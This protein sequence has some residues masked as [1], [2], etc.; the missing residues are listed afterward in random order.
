MFLINDHLFSC[1][2]STQFSPSGILTPNESSLTSNWS[3][4]RIG[5]FSTGRYCAKKTLEC[6]GF[7]HHDILIGENRE[8]LWPDG[9]TGSISHCDNLVGAITA[10]TAKVKAIGLDIEIIGRVEQELWELVFTST[11]RDFLTQLTPELAAVNSTIIFSAKECFYKLQYPL[12]KI[13][14]D[15]KDVEIFIEDESLQISFV[16]GFEEISRL[17]QNVVMKYI[18]YN[19]EVITYGYLL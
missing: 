9:V 7:K 4:K 17:F 1:F 6:L 19:T 12:T 8:P 2:F 11:E 18:T 13:Y 5:E 15:F 10:S 16:K 3:I 14:I